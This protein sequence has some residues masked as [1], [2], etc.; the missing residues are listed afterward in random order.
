VLEL[1]ARE[2]LAWYI[3]IGEARHG[4]WDYD[5]MNWTTP[6]TAETKE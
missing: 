3:A 5:D 1:S 6:I 2:Q 4:K